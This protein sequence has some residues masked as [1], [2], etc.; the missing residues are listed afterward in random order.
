MIGWR[1]QHRRG[2]AVRSKD[3]ATKENN[4]GH[5]TNQPMLEVTAATDLKTGYSTTP[6]K[7]STRSSKRMCLSL[8]TSRTY[9]PRWCNSARL[10]KINLRKQPYSKLA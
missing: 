4:C 5:C 9:R 2:V 10:R 7:S 6:L 1:S 3:G 8:K